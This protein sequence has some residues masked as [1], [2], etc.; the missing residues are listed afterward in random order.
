METTNGSEGSVTAGCD[1]PE[2]EQ[3]LA[4]LARSREWQPA[5]LSLFCVVCVDIAYS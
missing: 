3:V 1:W 5:A 2:D 4:S